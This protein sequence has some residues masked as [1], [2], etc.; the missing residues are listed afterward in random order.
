MTY[1][2][3]YTDPDFRREPKTRCWCVVCQ[4][5]ITST[6]PPLWVAYE[7]DK[8]PQIIHPA[9]LQA[10]RDD[11]RAAR[12]EYTHPH[13]LIQLERVGSECARRLKGWTMNA[14]E[15]DAAV[16]LMQEGTTL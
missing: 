14:A 12:P 15:H 6:K 9:D 10:A 11:I 1:R 3:M 4:R 5:D 16:K 2:T 13:D 7:L 8:F